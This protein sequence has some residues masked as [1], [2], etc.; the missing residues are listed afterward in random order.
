MEAVKTWVYR[1]MVNEALR[2]I[3]KNRKTLQET[4]DLDM[5]EGK[6]DTY[7]N[8]DLR[9]ALH[10][11]GE[12]DRTIVILRYFEDLKIEDIAY[13]LKRNVSTI[14]SRLYRAM[15]KLRKSLEEA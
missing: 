15:A 7:P 11:L 12:P 10:N 4:K 8:Q 3:Q 2:F 6:E 1:I 9:N 13:I 14:K 5:E